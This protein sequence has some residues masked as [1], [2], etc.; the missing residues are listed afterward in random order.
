MA[1]GNKNAIPPKNKKGQKHY[2]PPTHKQIKAA[3]LISENRMTQGQALKEAGYNVGVQ[4]NPQRVT[5]SLG[6]QEVLARYVDDDKL[7]RVLNEGLEAKKIDKT[8]LG[9][10]EDNEPIFHREEEV[11]YNARHKYLD[12]VLKAKGVYK[13][14]INLG[15]GDSLL[16]LLGGNS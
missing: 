8:Y 13:Q 7:A 1:Q 16:D 10:D 3:K 9:N 15:L 12:T 4:K 14:D 2:R 5:E 6:F 11:D